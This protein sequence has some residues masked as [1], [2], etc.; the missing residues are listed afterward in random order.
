MPTTQD[1]IQLLI[2]ILANTEALEKIHI[3][4]DQG[5]RTLYVQFVDLDDEDF[6]EMLEYRIDAFHAAM[7][8]VQVESTGEEPK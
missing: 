7:G 1:Q 3:E 8:P 2:D 5:T 4:Q 6:R